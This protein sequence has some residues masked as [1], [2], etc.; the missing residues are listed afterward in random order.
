MRTSLLGVAVDGSSRV[1]AMRGTGEPR[2]RPSADI[3][4]SDRH[5]PGPDRLA[6]RIPAEAL[7]ASDARGGPTER[8]HHRPVDDGPI[9]V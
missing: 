3:R 5:P 1:P 2:N 8:P 7:R 6:H 9:Q 4:L